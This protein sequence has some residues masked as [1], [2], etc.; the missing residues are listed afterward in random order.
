MEIQIS[1]DVIRRISRVSRVLPFDEKRNWLRSIFI[2]RRNDHAW[3][4]ATNSYFAAIEYLGND[5]GENGFA[6]LSVDS[7]PEEMNPDESCNIK[8]FPLLNWCS[9]PMVTEPEANETLSNW[10]KWIS[11][12]PS[13][14]GRAMFVDTIGLYALAMSSPSGRVTFPR[15]I[16]AEKS[17]IVRDVASPDWL[18]VFLA[19]PQNGLFRDG[20]IRPKWSI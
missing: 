18:G 16:D 7:F 10:R 12:E 17:I 1:C 15:A 4:G 8:H 11:P 2:E 3:I 20:A 19:R 6:V 5:A 13:E 9:H 14:P